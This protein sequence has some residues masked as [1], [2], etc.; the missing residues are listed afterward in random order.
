MIPNIPI[1]R[2]YCQRK[3]HYFWRSLLKLVNDCWWKLNNQLV[4]NIYIVLSHTCSIFHLFRRQILFYVK[5]FCLS[6]IYS[7]S[8]SILFSNV[9]FT[10]HKLLDSNLAF[11]RWI[12]LYI[13]YLSLYFYFWK[14]PYVNILFRKSFGRRLI[15]KIIFCQRFLRFCIVHNMKRIYIAQRGSIITLC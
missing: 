14:K 13:I 9:Y 2:W 11:D 1:I 3:I 10:F 12:K 5:T 7:S 4:L 8:S 15:V 6:Y